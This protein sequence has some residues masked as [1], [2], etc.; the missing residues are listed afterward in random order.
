MFIE[1]RKSL[2]VEE[3][4]ANGSVSL[5]DLTDKLGVSQATIRRDLTEL[6]R[7]GLLKRTHGGAVP[8]EQIGRA[9]V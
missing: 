5:N 8:A 1:Q 4:T 6:E 3:L 2:I 9:H 7:S